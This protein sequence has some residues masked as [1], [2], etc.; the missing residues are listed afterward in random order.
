MGIRAG[1]QELI[2][3]LRLQDPRQGLRPRRVPA[4]RRRACKRA[5]MEECHSFSRISDTLAAFV[6]E[7]VCI[8]GG[9]ITQLEQREMP[10]ILRNARADAELCGVRCF[11]E[12]KPMSFCDFYQRFAIELDAD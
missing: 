11:L 9:A 7:V 10:A 5:G 8:H 2:L 6:Q 12:V 4:L 1:N 3:V